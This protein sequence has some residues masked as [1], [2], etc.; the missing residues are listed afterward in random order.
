M[1]TNERQ[2]KITKAWLKKFE[3]SAAVHEQ[4]PPRPD[5]HPTIH[6]AGADALR[7]EAEALREQL[8]EYERLRAGHVKQRTLSSLTELPKAIIEAR[9]AAH[10]TQK[11]LAK[12]LGV[13]E[14]QVQ[15]W[16]TSEYSGVS[17]ERMQEIADALGVRITETIRFQPA[18]ERGR[19]APASRVQRARSRK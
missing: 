19:S 10:V 4:T 12:R 13:A 5:V 3:A 11:G 16:E 14:Q 8:E 1:I 18:R 15:R 7:S 9:I 2:Y 17:V 6:Q